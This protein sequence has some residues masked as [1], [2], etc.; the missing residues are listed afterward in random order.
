VT[1]AQIEQLTAGIS[2]LTGDSLG[3]RAIKVAAMDL[4][5]SAPRSV[6]LLAELSDLATRQAVRDGH[7]RAVAA[8]FAHRTSRAGDPQ[9]HTHVLVFNRALGV[10][11]RW[12]A[13]HSRR[14]FAWAKTAG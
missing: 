8:G 3:Q 4:T 13:V 12:G 2:P 7:D 14:V 1:V 9:L 5:F 11:R 10:D 6:S